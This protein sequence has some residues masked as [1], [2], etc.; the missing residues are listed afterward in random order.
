MTIIMNEDFLAFVWQYQYL[1]PS[2]LF[3]STGE[4]IKVINTGFRNTNAGPDFTG[5]RLLLGR[6][7]WVGCIE[8]H[9]RSSEWMQHQHQ[10]DPVYES[11]ILHVVWEDD[12]PVCHPNGTAVPTLILKDKINE[13]IRDRYELLLQKTD[14]IPCGRYFNTAPEIYKINMSERLLL[15][16]L[17][18]KSDEILLLLST[19]QN[20]WEE[21]TYQFLLR[22]YGG[23]VNAEPFTRLA[24]VLPWKILRK[25]HRNLLQVEALL[26]GCAGLLPEESKEDYILSLKREY[27]FLSQKY[28][29]ADFQ[30]G[31]HEW[32]FLRIRP[33]GF[34]TI[35]LAQLAAFLCQQSNLFS[36]F[37][38]SND[39]EVLIAQLRTEQSEYWKHHF[40]TGEKSKSPIPAMGSHTA[41]SLVINVVLPLLVAYNKYLDRG[42]IIPDKVWAWLGKLPDE[43]NKILRMWQSLGE[44]VNNAADSQ[45]LLEWY[46]RYCEKKKCLDCGVGSYIL[47]N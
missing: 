34:P 8:V 37:N 20:D 24:Q 21:T 19:N 39:L 13:T 27:H 46:T 7:E 25:H 14:P 9:F 38:T 36:F 1:H 22:Y 42:E 40:I 35:R 15:E 29:L 12:Q 16:R 44:H 17:N 26:F 30:M 45:A 4:E 10:Y 41:D 5:S 31:Y 32:K 11:V 3:T 6:L 28:S 2:Q 47:R 18:R 33:A 23:T 43:K